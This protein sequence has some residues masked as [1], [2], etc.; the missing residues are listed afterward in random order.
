VLSLATVGSVAADSK[1]APVKAAPGSPT[2]SLVAAERNLTFDLAKKILPD[3]NAIFSPASIHVALGM[4]YAG[5][6]GATADEMARVLGYD[7]AGGQA[8]H[9]LFGTLGTSLAKLEHKDQSFHMVNR[10]FGQAKYDWSKAY[11]ALTDKKY[12][13]SLEPVS[14]ATDPEKVRLHINSWVE[15]QT[16]KKIKDLLPKDSLSR[17]TRLVL[18]NAVYFKGSWL[19]QFDK[20]ATQD[21]GFF[22]RGKTSAKVPMMKQID[23]FNLGGNADAAVLELPY[24]H[25]DI[26][27]DIILP[28]KNDGLP[29]LEAKL[30]GAGLVKLLATMKSTNVDVAVPKFKVRSSVSMKDMLSKLGMKTAFSRA[31]DFSGMITKAGEPLYI[32]QIYH[33]GFVDVDEQGTEAAAATAVVM[34]DESAPMRDPKATAFHADHPFVW[35]IRDLKTGEILFY[36]R[37]V[38]PR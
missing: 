5:A 29:A 23:Q 24:S 21:T 8:V 14:F 10:L 22:A 30:D 31:A 32:D 28:R 7:R 6:R 37:V 27:M 3:E 16:N 11:L 12:G 18:T 9:D 25:G 20:R 19:H 26:A 33:Q 17:D 13:A 1:P 15:D 2:D 36:G 34:N 35:L 4:T 38:D